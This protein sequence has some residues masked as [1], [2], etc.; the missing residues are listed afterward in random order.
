MKE[1]IT[2]N[3][4]PNIFKYIDYRQFLKDYYSHKKAGS[5]EY[6]YQILTNKIGL[7]APSHLLYIINGKRNISSKTLGSFAKALGLS[8]REQKYF[9]TLVSFNQAKNTHSR[10]SYYEQLLPLYKKE[11][12]R[13]L[14]VNQYR[15]LSSWYGPVIL[16]MIRL[17]N[18]EESPHWIA[19]QL[20]NQITPLQAKE[21]LSLLIEL[22]LVKRDEFDK[23]Q[24]VDA[25]I[26]TPETVRDVAAL[27]FQ[28]QMIEQSQKALHESK[29]ETWKKINGLTAALSPE[30]LKRIEEHLREFR[31]KL[32]VE[33]EKSDENADAVYQL[34]INFFSV[35]KIQG[36]TNE[37]C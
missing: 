2:Q 11:H 9:D 22:E 28:D 30:Q 23:L 25:H 12:G 29:E 19:R 3:Q 13:K 24:V 20:K 4:K 17:K 35:T 26:T 21:M 32:L 8:D 16:E 27:E 10:K 31:N 18:F 37:T 15:F 6:S 34:N 1:E 7:C 36:D 5:R 14:K 33:L